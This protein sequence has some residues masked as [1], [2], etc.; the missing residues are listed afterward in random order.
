MVPPL[1]VSK[2]AD[3][4]P[5]QLRV[6]YTWFVHFWGYQ[7]IRFDR[8]LAIPAGSPGLQTTAIQPDHAGDCGVAARDAARHGAAAGLQAGRLAPCQSR[9]DGVDPRL[10]HWFVLSHGLLEPGSIL[11]MAAAPGGGSA[12]GGHAAADDDH[13]YRCRPR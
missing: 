1:A 10:L 4:R 9:R 2:A 8:A 7:S 5:A 13:Q 6:R 11:F 3:A 12:D